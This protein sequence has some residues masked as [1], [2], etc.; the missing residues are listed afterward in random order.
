MILPITDEYRIKTDEHNWTIQRHG[1]FRKNR[2]TGMKEP[3]WKDAGYYPSLESAING[4]HQ[5]M[6]RLCPAKSLLEVLEANEHHLALLTTALTP[7]FK[8]T[9]V[10]DIDTETKNTANDYAG[11]LDGAHGNA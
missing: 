3:N 8:V 1:G 5:R 11:E 10:V 9:Q 7:K 2:Q 4:L 6:L